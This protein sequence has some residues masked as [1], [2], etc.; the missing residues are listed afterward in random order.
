M[1]SKE[2]AIL[3]DKIASLLREI[4][5]AI[6]V[7]REDSDVSRINA[8]AAGE[9]V[10]VGNHTYAMLS[11]CKTLF[12]ETDGAFTPSLYNLTQ[13]W[14]FSPDFE[15][16]YSIPREEPSAEAIAAAAELSCFEDLT[17]CPNNTVVKAK[18]GLQIDLGGIAKGYMSDVSAKLVTDY[19]S[20]RQVDTFL[21]VMSNAVFIG[22]KRG[23]NADLGF[24][25]TIENPRALVDQ[26]QDAA[27]GLFMISLSDVSVSTSADTYRFFVQDDRIYSHIID[28]HT[29]KPSANGVISITVI[30]PRNISNSGAL[31]DAYSTAGFCM[32]L[33]Q[34]I[35]FYE[36]MAE[37]KGLSAVILTA[38][39]NYYVIGNAKICNRTEYAE[40]ISPGYDIED[41]FNKAE[42]EMAQDFVVPC[43]KE[44]E[45]IRLVAEQIQL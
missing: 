7:D 31:A 18:D 19:F 32:P 1:S 34:A 15:G 44:T 45:Y 42:V 33:T 2:R 16:K 5:D 35:A 36:R 30:M 8:A 21:S 26:G 17:L 14:G 4:E 13:L 9:S 3:A 24:T 12:E 43:E 27:K 39:Y 23:A 6:C 29:G 38:D 40:L 10:V 25:A 11:L 41:F 22:Q 28:P 20:N 37:S